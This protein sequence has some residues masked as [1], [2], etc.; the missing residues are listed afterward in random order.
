MKIYDEFTSKI[1][2]AA[3]TNSLAKFVERLCAKLGIRSIGSD[4]GVRELLAHND[5]A[6]LSLFR[7][8]TQFIVLLMREVIEAKKEGKNDNQI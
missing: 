5:H 8:E 7:D 6:I 1:K 4:A 3:S 2:S